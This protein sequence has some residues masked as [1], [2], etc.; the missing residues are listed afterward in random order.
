MINKSVNF[1]YDICLSHGGTYFP[2]LWKMANVVPAHRKNDERNIKS[3]HPVSLLPFFGKIFEHLLYNQMYSF[4]IENNL[5][6]LNQSGFRQGDSSINQLISTTHEIYRSMDQGYE[7]RGVFLD[8]SIAFDKVWY[9]G[10][11]H[12]LKENR[13]DGPLLNVLEDLLSSRKQIVVLNGQHSSWNDVIAGV[14]QVSILGPILF[15][16]YIN[17]LSEGLHSNPKLFADDTSLFSTVPDITETTNELN[18]DLREIN[19]WAHQCKM[20]K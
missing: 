20:W 17:D 14:P 4:F 19:I 18:N 15:L 10:L 16:T 7:V 9:R 5:I 3:Y 13:I 6:S 12:K 2:L 11:L 1:T 8:I